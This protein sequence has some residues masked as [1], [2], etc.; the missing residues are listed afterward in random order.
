[1]AATSSGKSPRATSAAVTTTVLSS[2]GEVRQTGRRAASEDDRDQALARRR[3][4]PGHG[5]V[6]PA[7]KAITPE[8]AETRGVPMGRDCISYR[9]P[10]PGVF[11]AARPSSNSS[12][13]CVRC[14]AA[15]RSGSSCASGIHGEFFGIAK[16]M[17]E[18]GILPDFIVVDWCGG[19]HGSER[20]WSSP[21][22]S[23]CRCR[24]GCYWCTTRWSASAC[25]QRIRIGASGKMITHSTSRRRAC[26][27]RGLGQRGAWLHVR[28]R[29]HSG[30]DLP[31]R[32]LPDGRRDAGPCASTRFG[33]SGQG[34]TCIQLPSPTRC[35]R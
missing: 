8:I 19:R 29:L 15:S 24:K 26:H 2:A 32:T 27:R 18:T 14:P 4:K 5:G 10:I 3:R 33:G 34:R 21:I 28:R 1:M 6:L 16:A 31:H 35:M 13:V 23:A 20:R 30:A 7:A 11:D 22:T 17:L 12:T 25:V 9:L